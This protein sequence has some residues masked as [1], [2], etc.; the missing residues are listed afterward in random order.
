MEPEAVGDFQL[1][2]VDLGI[3]TCFPLSR[4]LNL[5]D[6]QLVRQILQSPGKDLGQDAV[7]A[8]DKSVNRMLVG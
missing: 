2:P 7:N 1:P 4:I 5:P 6:F 8:K 3:T